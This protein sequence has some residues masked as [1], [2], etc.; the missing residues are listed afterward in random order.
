M[1]DFVKRFAI[2]FAIGAVLGVIIGLLLTPSSEASSWQVT[3]ASYYNIPGGTTACGQTMTAS[4]W[5]VAHLG[6][7]KSSCGKQLR[8][9]KRG[10]TRCVNVSVRDTGGYHYGRKWDLTPRVKYALRCP[11]LCNVRWISR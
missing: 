7:T 10:T 4:S 6:G 3:K 11:D 5:W 1:S 9:C 8:I 2:C